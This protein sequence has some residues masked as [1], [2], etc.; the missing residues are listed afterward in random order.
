MRAF[1]FLPPAMEEIAEA[2]EYYE[3]CAP[4]LGGGFL[5]E[6]RSA[7]DQVPR[8]RV[9]LFDVVTAVGIGGN[10]GHRRGVGSC[11]RH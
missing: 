3:G 6:V 2:A 4:S 8:R 7:V 10:A 9:C 1:K 11:F 5:A